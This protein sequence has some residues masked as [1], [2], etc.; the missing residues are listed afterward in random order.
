MQRHIYPLLCKQCGRPAKYYFHDSD[1]DMYFVCGKCKNKYLYIETTYSCAYCGTKFS[2]K[3]RPIKTGADKQI[4]CV[5]CF[6]LIKSG[7]IRTD[8]GLKK[9]KCLGGKID[10]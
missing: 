9:I 10:L 1:N 3:Y 8:P 4:T 6:K 5:T 7:K 2:T